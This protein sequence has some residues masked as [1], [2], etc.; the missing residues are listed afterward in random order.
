MAQ[1]LIDGA[2]GFEIALRNE[3]DTLRGIFRQWNE[4][5]KSSLSSDRI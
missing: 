2:G 5:K 3:P 4:I 1:N